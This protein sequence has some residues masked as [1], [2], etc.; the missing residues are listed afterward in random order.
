[1]K[2]IKSIQDKVLRRSNIIREKMLGLDFTKSVDSKTLGLDHLEGDVFYASSLRKDLVEVLD[3]LK[4]RDTHKI[5]DFG[6]GKGA[7]MLTMNR[8]QFSEISGVEIS[9]DLCRIADKNFEILKMPHLKVYESD[10]CR[11]T[12]IDAFSHFYFFHPFSRDITHIVLNNIRE[13][14][15]R[16]PREICLIYYNPGYREIFDEREEMHL[17]ASFEGWKYQTLVYRYH[18]D[19]A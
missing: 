12:E 16:S 7:A 9:T 17:Y 6:A 15:R 10:A 11:F 4:I 18:K 14:F 5:L 3:A 1:M 19:L 2:L 8:Y 13:S